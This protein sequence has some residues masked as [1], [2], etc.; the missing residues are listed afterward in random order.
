VAGGLATAGLLQFDVIEE[1]GEVRMATH[2]NTPGSPVAIRAWLEFL[3]GHWD[4]GLARIV[5]PYALEG[6]AHGTAP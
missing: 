2:S 6:L 5:D 4:D 1:G 3:R